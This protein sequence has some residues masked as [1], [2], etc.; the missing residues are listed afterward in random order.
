MAESVVTDPRGDHHRVRFHW[1]VTGNSGKVALSLRESL[2]NNI[3]S[4]SGLGS[5]V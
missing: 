4:A 1:L 5:D 2:V 3:L